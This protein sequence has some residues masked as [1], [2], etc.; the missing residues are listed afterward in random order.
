MRAR[1]AVLVFPLASCAH[2]A[3]I[4]TPGKPAIE[5]AR[6]SRPWGDLR[7]DPRTEDRLRSI[8]RAAS[9]GADESRRLFG[10]V[11]VVAPGLWRLINSD[12]SLSEAGTPS[13]SGQPQPD[14]SILTYEMRSYY[15]DADILR[16]LSSGTFIAAMRRFATGTIRAATSDERALLY[17]QIPFEILDQPIAVS[18]DR[19]EVL[20]AVL[21]A[22]GG[23]DWIEV[24]PARR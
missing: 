10:G 8:I 19:D 24:L 20:I 5:A 3:I 21:G 9:N 6:H 22:T 1:L 18:E 13:Y 23:L 4:F 12:P 16:L 15:K 14:G 17:R 2:H 7:T 11:I